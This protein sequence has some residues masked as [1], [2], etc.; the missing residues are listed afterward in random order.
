MRYDLRE[1]EEQILSTLQNNPNMGGVNIRTHAGD[2]NP[3]AFYDE[4]T[5]EGL[6]NLLPFV[7]VQ[8][9]GR[10]RNV[11]SSTW[12]QLSHVLRFS[13]YV[14]AE[15]LS[16]KRMAQLNCYAM[17]ASVFDSLNARY[18]KS[19]QPLAPDT[20]LLDGDAIQTDFTAL[21]PLREADGENERL[22]VNLP[23]IACYQTD[24]QIE[25]LS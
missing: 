7:F 9:S 18:P 15:S 11:K 14:G 5:L 25:V 24:Y 13:L 17:L 21:S 19:S 12:Q 23:S 16:E 6:T 3:S 2:L 20:P 22:L 8:Y 10:V 4:Q 1:I